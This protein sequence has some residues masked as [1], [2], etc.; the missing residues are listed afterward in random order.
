MVKRVRPVK[1][2]EDGKRL[3]SAPNRRTFR[4]IDI[5]RLKPPKEGQELYWDD[6][7]KGLSLLVGANTKTFR[8]T[9]KLKGRWTSTSI[10]RFGEM[11]PNSDP[12][13]ENL[14]I[15]EARRIVENYRALARQGIDPLAGPPDTS[16]DTYEAVV[17]L[18]IDHYAKPKQRTWDQTQRV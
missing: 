5:K 7:C 1:R 18:F 11:V 17:D 2:R 9:Y 13:K 15:G 10:G 6:A 16:K 3:R 12:N 8:A 4:D 14:Q